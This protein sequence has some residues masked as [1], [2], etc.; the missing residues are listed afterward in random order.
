[1]RRLFKGLFYFVNFVL[2][3]LL[4]NS[5]GLNTLERVEN[6]NYNEISDK[7]EIVFAEGDES[8]QKYG[9]VEISNVPGLGNNI[10]Y[11]KLVGK[12]GKII[13]LVTNTVGFSFY[14][15]LLEDCKIV[16]AQ[17]IG[18]YT[19]FEIKGTYAIS[20]LNKAKK[21]ISKDI[22]I[23]QDDWKYRKQQLITENKN[24]SY[25]VAHFEKVKVVGVLT[26]C[27]GHSYGSKP[28]FLTVKKSSGEIGYIGYNDK[29][30]YKDNPIDESWDKDIIDLIKAQKIIIGMTK[31]QILLSWGEPETKNRTVGSWGVHEQWI[32]G[33]KYLYFE[34][35]KLTSFQD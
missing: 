1:M 32:Y 18:E 10:S 11:N 8:L 23:R 34:N 16:Y 14:K 31:E 5:C 25:P 7:V 12:R 15:I 30:F 19:E 33:N 6:C 26:K 3:L 21:L 2:V 27:L 4:F 24:I 20:E 13:A 9:Y 35:D 17:K 22:W 29:N 28:F